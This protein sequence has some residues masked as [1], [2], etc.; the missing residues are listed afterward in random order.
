MSYPNQPWPPPGPQP[1]QPQPGYPP[2]YPQY[3]IGYGAPA[4]RLTLD[5]TKVAAIAV[6]VCGVAVLIGSLFA[7]YSVSVIPSALPSR[8][9]D[10]PAG[11]VDLGI[12][13]YD[14]VPF[15]PP[16]VAEAIPVLMVLAALTAVPLLFGSSTKASPVPS[17]LA[18]T[19][20]L[21]AVALAIK[22]PLPSVDVTGQMAAKL[23]EETG[24]Q[25]INSMIDA[26]VSVSPGAGLI[27]SI[28]FSL[29]AWG[30][31]ASLAFQRNSPPP[32]PPPQSIPPSMPPP[33]PY[34]Q[35][36]NPAPW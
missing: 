28:V 25:N 18:G 14:V 1:G 36:P 33:M 2:G 20:A 16:I 30:A 23:S 17:V 5:R 26:V 29:L 27:V 22:G 15:A 6:V 35:P 12:G 9:N 24:G 34:P 32:P 3:P 21:L 19:A 4:P 11:S 7:L 13:F 10:A 8:E 31:A